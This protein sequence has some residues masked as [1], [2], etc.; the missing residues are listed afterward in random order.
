MR[1]G[2][3]IWQAGSGTA[4]DGTSYF[5][6]T[7]NGDF[8][9]VNNFGE[10]AVQLDA[11]TLTVVHSWAPSNNGVLSGEDADLSSGR[12]MLLP[13][14]LIAFGAKDWRVRLLGADLSLLQ[15]LPTNPSPPPTDGNGGV[16]GGAFAAG[17]GYF[18]NQPGPLYAFP[19]TGSFGTPIPTAASY[20]SVQ[21]VAVTPGIVWIT[22]TATSPDSSVATGTLRALN[23]ST[24]AELWTAPLGNA[25]KF[26]APTVANGRVYVGN[27]DGVERMFSTVAPTVPQGKV[28]IS[29]ISWQQR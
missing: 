5:L 23:S 26:S 6:V 4:T 7:G 14:G 2:G 17:V 9:G 13:G 20:A 1:C 21:G 19:F 10:A 15:D 25:S 12:A 28:S 27:E 18:P 24:L 22:T 16:W 8:D 29:L 11:A 3:G